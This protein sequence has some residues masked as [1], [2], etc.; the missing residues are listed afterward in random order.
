MFPTSNRN[1]I[2]T[3]SSG[4][5]P[6]PFIVVLGLG[7]GYGLRTCPRDNLELW[8][9]MESALEAPRVGSHLSRKKRLDVR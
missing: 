7:T 6:T 2:R 1:R 8:T 5:I 3:T 9:G 4:E